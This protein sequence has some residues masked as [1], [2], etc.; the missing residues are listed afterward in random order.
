MK[1]EGEKS[2]REKGE[3]EK[4]KEDVK[5]NQTDLHR[6]LWCTSKIRYT[7]RPQTWIQL[8]C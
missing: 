3:R 5:E 2:R 1:E 4:R 7:C 6:I 8:S